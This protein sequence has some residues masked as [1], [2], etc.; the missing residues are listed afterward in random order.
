MQV[1][2]AL[3]WWLPPFLFFAIS[4]SAPAESSG[5]D[6]TPSGLATV[7]VA[8]PSQVQLLWNDDDNEPI[9]QLEAAR[10]KLETEGET[11]LLLAN[12]GIYTPAQAPSGLHVEEGV[13]LVPLNLNEGSG[14]FHL[15]PNGVF[16]IEQLATGSRA[17]VIESNAYNQLSSSGD[18]SPWLAVQ[19]GPLLVIDGQ[20]HPVFNPDSRSRFVR[21]G[22]GVT[23]EGLVA[24]IQS[25]R[26]ITF[27]DFAQEFISLGIDN[28]LYLDGSI[29][30]TV[31]PQPGQAISPHTPYAGILAVVE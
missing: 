30:R 24:I 2:K 29:V 5:S 1:Q 26:S 17:A 10:Q 9:G 6:F 4:C 19:S 27:W 31:Q 16:V 14:N 18:L 15:M 12:A 13:E 28:A 7:F 8:A 20:P 22:I 25:R 3:L 21:N 11:V 23:D